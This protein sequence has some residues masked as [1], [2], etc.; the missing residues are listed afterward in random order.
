MKS[1]SYDSLLQWLRT[2]GIDKHP[3]YPQ[4]TSLIYSSGSDLS[5]FWVVPQSGRKQ[6][7]FLKTML[8]SIPAWSSVFVWRL[9]GWPYPPTDPENMS[10]GVEYQ[11]FKGLGLTDGKVEIVEFE[12]GE[13]DRLVT[14]LF[15]GT[16]FG[17]SVAED[18]YV[19]PSHARCFL[20]VSHHDVVHATFREQGDLDAMIARM[21]EAK[22]PL[23]TEPPDGTFKI[24]SWMKGN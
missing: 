22:Y 12:Q 17:W 20:K 23:P 4:S 2:Q 16:A 24:P 18:I 3:K 8:R 13:L 6:V 14:L 21:E 11:I 5:R 15:A 9:G 1:Q 19:I 7:Y 10:N